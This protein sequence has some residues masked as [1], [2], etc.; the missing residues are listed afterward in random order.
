MTTPIAASTVNQNSVVMMPGRASVVPAMKPRA[1]RSRVPLTCDCGRPSVRTFAMTSSL[2][3]RP[4]VLAVAT[5]QCIAGIIF[6]EGI[7]LRVIPRGQASRMETSGSVR[8]RRGI[9]RVV[10][11]SSIAGQLGEVRQAAAAF[12]ID[13]VADALERTAHEALAVAETEE[14]VE[15]AGQLLAVARQAQ[16]R[17]SLRR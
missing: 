2:R 17:R 16:V 4:R 3:P 9:M 7:R 8:Y 1:R 10:T 5:R 15:L 12:G 6:S 11:P 14:E 13:A